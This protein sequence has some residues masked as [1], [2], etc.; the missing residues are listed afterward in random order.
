MPPLPEASGTQQADAPQQH[1]QEQVDNSYDLSEIQGQ[2]AQSQKALQSVQGE[3]SSVRGDAA[4]ANEKLSS[5]KRFFTEEEAPKED[6]VAKKVAALES[7]MDE[8]IE[9]A[10]QAERA[11]RPIPL[12]VNT[13]IS[14]LQH[15]IETLKENTELKKQLGDLGSK[16]SQLSNPENGLNAQ[17]YANLDNQLQ[18]SLEHIYGTDNPKF[19]EQQFNAVARLIGDEI[20]ELQ[21]EDPT[22][23]RQL[24]NSPEKQA[25][26]VN[27]Y[28]QSV[29]PPQARQVI[30]NERIR[31]TPLSEQELW[32][33]FR[34]ANELSQN[35]NTEAER[36]QAARMA[37]EIRQEILS[38]RWTK[39]F[40]AK[41]NNVTSLF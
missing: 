3:L 22:T 15:Q 27:Y 37:S 8:Y 24:R 31:T 10:L 13:A 34:E 39:G 11:G 29:I 20:K 9:A 12:T 23:W 16:V 1:G 38:S 26:L 18:R 40:R 19:L 21:H 35:A 36:T 32:A 33:A 30:E 25:K 7:Q 41:S 14:N 2:L 17:T 28:V 6:P 4:K 5:L